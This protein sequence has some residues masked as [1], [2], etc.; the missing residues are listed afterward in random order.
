MASSRH[1]WSVT[2]PTPELI[3]AAQSVKRRMINSALPT[4][5]KSRVA[6]ARPPGTL[7]TQVAMNDAAKRSLGQPVLGSRPFKRTARKVT[8]TPPM[9]VGF[10]TDVSGSM[11]WSSTAV[12]EACWI[13][14]RGAAHSGARVAALTFGERVDATY[15]PGEV[16]QEV[17]VR[18]ATDGTE[19]AD[20]A[21]AA[22]DGA[23]GLS[24]TDP[25]A[26]NGARLLVVVSD[27]HYTWTESAKF[28]SHIARIT[29]AG[30]HVLIVGC[31]D[32]QAD[33]LRRNVA[34][35]NAKVP[36][37]KRPMNMPAGT[38]LNISL[39]TLEDEIPEQRWHPNWSHRLRD[40]IVDHVLDRIES[41]RDEARAH[42]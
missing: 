31:S 40:S 14:A 38:I 11:S 3:G 28:A 36:P 12:G 9:V 13:L 19:S 22:I 39:Q 32:N 23:L 27:T 34:R 6:T 5:A 41:I 30:T 29:L 37:N 25:R 17:I 8:T 26:R 20:R 10:A 2:A 18:M 16:P 33:D 15:L 7:R 35:I 21:M 1:Y 4:V 42:H 24:D